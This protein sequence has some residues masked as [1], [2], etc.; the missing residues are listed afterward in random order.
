MSA[1]IEAKS[2]FL[3]YPLVRVTDRRTLYAPIMAGQQYRGPAE[4]NSGTFS[5]AVQC[6]VPT[7]KHPVLQQAEASA[8]YVPEAVR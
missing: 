2:L 8:K 3:P 1:N 5:V 6:P 4:K 7:L